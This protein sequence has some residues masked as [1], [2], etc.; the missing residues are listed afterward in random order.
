MAEIRKVTKLPLEFLAHIIYN[1]VEG[2]IEDIHK[3]EL[4]FYGGIIF[5]WK[6]KEKTSDST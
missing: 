3:I 5:L 1:I 2:T 6:K 4:F